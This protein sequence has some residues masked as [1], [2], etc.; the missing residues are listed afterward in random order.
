MILTDEQVREIQHRSL[1]QGPADLI[2]A[3]AAFQ[4]R[5][6]LIRSHEQLREEVLRLRAMFMSAVERDGPY[7]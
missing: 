2:A 4:D 6:D 7:A 1:T 5:R 3:A